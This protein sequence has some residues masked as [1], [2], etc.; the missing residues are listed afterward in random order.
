MLLTG[1][2]AGLDLVGGHPDMCQTDADPCSEAQVGPQYCVGS[3][4]DLCRDGGWQM[5]VVRPVESGPRLQSLADSIA[6]RGSPELDAFWDEVASAGTPLIEPDETDPS[7]SLVTFL[8]RA[9]GVVENV[10][11]YGGWSRFQWSDDLSEMQ[12]VRLGATDC[13]YRTYRMPNA[14]R[15]RYWFGSNDSLEPWTSI[16]HFHEAKCRLDAMVADPLNSTVLVGA[17][18]PLASVL[19]LPSAPP[20]PWGTARPGV[21]RGTLQREAFHS[22]VLGNERTVWTYL[23]PVHRGWR[24]YHMLVA[25]DGEIYVGVVPTPIILD[26]LLA[27]GRVSSTVAVFVANAGATEEEQALSRI[28]ELLCDPA[29][30]ASWRTARAMDSRSIQRVR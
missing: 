28:K 24:P 10:V 21:A 27:A 25:F 11:V 3:L 30:A 20:Q 5:E 1:K 16:S 26:N 8:W 6:G 15:A 2:I 14:L 13:W 22:E 29:F 19:S 12:L 4:S 23:P 18:V 9:S 7:C 17:H